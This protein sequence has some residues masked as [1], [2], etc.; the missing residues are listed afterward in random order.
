MVAAPFFMMICGI[1]EL[2]L[3]FMF[4]VSLENAT[5][6]LARKIRTGELQ[7]TGTATLASAK[8]ELCKNLGWLSSECGTK[9][10]LD[11]RKFSTLA[12]TNNQGAWITNKAWNGAECFRMG[13][14]SDIILVRAY[15]EWD[16]IA[17]G[18]N[19][20]LEKLDGGKTVIGATATF[21]NEPYGAST[22]S[23]PC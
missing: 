7:G 13:G 8:T 1:I 2:S 12:G 10:K 23:A 15:Y 19:Q 3:I 14:P 9:L 11:V 4:S 5:S 17:P 22:A 6:A 20:A 21:R 18:F 16:L